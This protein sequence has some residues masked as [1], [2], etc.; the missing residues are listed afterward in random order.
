M[1]LLGNYSTYKKCEFDLGR[2]DCIVI[3]SEESMQNVTGK[4]E[5]VELLANDMLC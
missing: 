5:E 3:M 4:S 1:K 2:V